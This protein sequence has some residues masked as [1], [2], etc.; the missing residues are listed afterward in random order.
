MR[1]N[2]YGANGIVVPSA[3]GDEEYA[4]DLKAIFAAYSSA[5][6]SERND[7]AAGSYDA[8][9]FLLLICPER[10]PC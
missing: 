1:F 9:Y 2:F 7:F 6:P 8:G 4:C 3:V 10:R 5:V